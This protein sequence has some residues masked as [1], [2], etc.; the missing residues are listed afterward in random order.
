MRLPLAQ[1]AEDSKNE[2]IQ[3]LRGIA[4]V[5]VVLHH[6]TWLQPAVPAIFWEAWSGVDV[7]FAISGYVVALSLSRTLK[8]SPGVGG[9]GQKLSQ[10]ASAIRSFLIR[11]FWR[12]IP[13]LLAALSLTAL[14]TL[15]L[16][17]TTWGHL[18][19]EILAALSMT[20]NYVVYGGGPFV[21]DVL[22]SLAVEMQFYLILPIFLVTFI[23]RRQQ[24]IAAGAV[25][26][27]IGLVVRPIHVHVFTMASHNWLAVRNA[28]HCRLDALAAGVF[29]FALLSDPT[30]A[31]AVR[32]LST[33]TIR[34]VAL[35]CI[36]VLLGIPAATSIEF[37]HTFGF[38]F[39]AAVSG[40]LVLV[41]A[42]AGG[43][44]VIP[45]SPL[46]GILRYTG[47]RSF[48]I[49]LIHR[50][51]PLAFF[52]A[53]PRVVA[54][55]YAPGDFGFRMWIIECVSIVVGTWIIAELMYQFVEKPSIT[56]GQYWASIRG[57]RQNNQ[58]VAS[59]HTEDSG[60]RPLASSR[61]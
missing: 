61:K 51:A 19:V 2:N 10:N 11:R 24:L 33:I 44:S 53:F 8:P 5:C 38:S 28:T 40:G 32:D 39:L 15:F 41:A 42:A 21:L 46:R 3:H 55:A 9:R 34:V 49:Y 43:F 4:I 14:L 22:W 12:I 47:E 16:G 59:R 56:A 27:S 13:P 52:K 7:F 37:S 1:S 58:A 30:T 25:F 35:F 45:L 6:F 50:L 31:Q 20:Y 18:S 26:L 29:V 36:M 23:T 48:S 54:G 60:S 17:I 57:S